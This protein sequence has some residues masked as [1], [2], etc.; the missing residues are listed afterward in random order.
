M[1]F[2]MLLCFVLCYRCNGIAP[3]TLSFHQV[4]NRLG[5]IKLAIHV[6]CRHFPA[7]HID[8]NAQSDWIF[9]IA[10]DFFRIVNDCLP[11][12]LDLLYTGFPACD[13][14]TESPPFKA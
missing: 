2:V 4:I 10:I 9:K 5:R 11:T 6:D 14:Q 13:T 7:C 1:L 8:G 12:V 3:F